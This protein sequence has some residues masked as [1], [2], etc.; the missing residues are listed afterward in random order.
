MPLW[1]LGIVGG[2]SQ[3]VTA[4]ASSAK[5]TN[6]FGTQTRAI[7]LTAETANVRVEFGPNP[8]AT[9]NSMLI[10]TSDPPLVVGIGAGD[11][12]AVIQDSSGGV[13]TVAELTYY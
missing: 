10:K 11:T 2:T 5:L 3:K 9:A 12:V 13:L 4:T 8:T 7:M 1:P 6:A